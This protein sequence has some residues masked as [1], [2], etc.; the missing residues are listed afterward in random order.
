MGWKKCTKTEKGMAG[1]V[2]HESHADGFFYI[3]SVVRYEFLHQGQT[4]NCWYYL[5][6]LRKC[7]EKKTS[8]VGKQLL[9]HPS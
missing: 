8:V 5:E 3:E 7:H 2:E 1:Q 4:V 9:V 6:V